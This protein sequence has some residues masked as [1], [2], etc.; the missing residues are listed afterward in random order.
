[1]IFEFNNRFAS[2]T[3]NHAQDKVLIFSRGTAVMLIVTY[4]LF[5]VFQLFTHKNIF[6]GESHGHTEK[7]SSTFY[8]AVSV[9]FGVTG[10]L[11]QNNHSSCCDLCRVFSWKY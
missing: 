11:K 5:I 1:L 9:L 2:V 7:P 4:A 8:A 10:I 6:I 3:E